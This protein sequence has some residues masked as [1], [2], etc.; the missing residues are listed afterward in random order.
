MTVPIRTRFAE[1]MKEE[2]RTYVWLAREAGITRQQLSYYANGLHCPDDTAAK[3]AKALG[4]KRA[5]VFP[6]STELAA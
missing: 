1:V 5:D 6:R 2:G 3:I 4:R